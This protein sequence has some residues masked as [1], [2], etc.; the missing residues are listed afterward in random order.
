MLMKVGIAIAVVCSFIVGLSTHSPI[1]ASETVA[2]DKRIRSADDFDLS[3]PQRAAVFDESGAELL[4]QNAIRLA[5]ENRHEDFF[6][7]IARALDAGACPTRALTDPAF[8]EIRDASTFRKLIAEH[9]R[10]SIAVIAGTDEPGRRMVI[11]GQIRTRAGK[12]ISVALVYAFHADASGFYNRGT[13]GDDN[14]RLYGFARTDAHGRFEFR[15]IRPAAYFSEA[16]AEQNVRF[17]VGAPG[18]KSAFARLGFEDDPEWIGCRSAPSWVRPVKRGSD[19]IERC[20]FCVLLD[21]VRQQ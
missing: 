14:P 2:A 7:A 20:V 4:Y 18:Y 16:D 1:P 6:D 10:Q 5:S 15:T 13:A 3:A 19:G 12:P 21:P 8:R 11:T 17:E 9:A